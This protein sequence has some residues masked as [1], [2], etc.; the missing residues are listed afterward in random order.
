MDIAIIAMA[1]PANPVEGVEISGETGKLVS[2][3]E[4]RGIQY[5]TGLP[6]G[7]T[8]NPDKAKL[9]ESTSLLGRRDRVAERPVE[10]GEKASKTPIILATREGPLAN[11][12]LIAGH[13]YS[14]LTVNSEN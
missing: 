9:S 8:M 7:E 2:A 6:F 10:L 12:K 1:T 3:N 5:L 14:V 11:T 4:Y 13:A